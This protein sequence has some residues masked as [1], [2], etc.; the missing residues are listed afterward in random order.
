M[1]LNIGTDNNRLNESEAIEEI[2]QLTKQLQNLH[3]RIP[4][5]CIATNTILALLEICRSVQS[6]GQLTLKPPL[7]PQPPIE[8]VKTPISSC[9]NGSIVTRVDKET[10]TCYENWQDDLRISD[11]CDHTNKSN[12]RVK[13]KSKCCEIANNNAAITCSTNSI[14]FDNLQ[15]QCMCSSDNNSLE[16]YQ[17]EDECCS[18]ARKRCGDDDSAQVESFR[19]RLLNFTSTTRGINNDDNNL[20]K[21]NSELVLGTN[22]Q[23]SPSTSVYKNSQSYR[24]S[25]TFDSCDNIFPP[26]S[27]SSNR[28]NNTTNKSN[29]SLSTESDQKSI[30]YSYL[31]RPSMKLSQSD[32]RNLRELKIALSSTLP[33]ANNPCSAVTSNKS[34]LIGNLKTTQII[35]HS[36]SSTSSTTSSKIDKISF[37]LSTSSTSD[38]LAKQRQQKHHHHHQI[39]NN[40]KDSKLMD[41]NEQQQQQQQYHQTV[42]CTRSVDNQN[43]NKSEDNKIITAAAVVA[44]CDNKISAATSTTNVN[45]NN[46]NNNGN[47]NGSGRR[48]GSG[49]G[50][51]GKLAIDL[52]DRSKYSD[53]EVTV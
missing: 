31:E 53:R 10:N 24:I 21:R 34:Q 2:K 4:Q 6:S 30:P 22:F 43:D 39:E 29:H 18:S 36:T 48:K 13:K 33:S 38:A 41:E 51:E 50:S 35:T 15:L 47:N 11:K 19:E 20:R 5:R 3:E 37:S 25:K 26:T 32:D 27:L 45:N 42:A 9:G 46:I 23:D 40:Q 14:N 49:K 12:K 17:I 7:T 44:S 16:E 1:C 52:N 28:T 8:Q